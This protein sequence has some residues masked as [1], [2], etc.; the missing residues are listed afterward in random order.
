MHVILETLARESVSC[1]V[2]IITADSDQTVCYKLR[3][4]S[5]AFCVYIT[6]K[7]TSTY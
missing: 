1:V 2:Q 4:F 3:L 7:K 6:T 5:A